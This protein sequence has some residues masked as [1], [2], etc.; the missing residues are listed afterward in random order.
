MQVKRRALKAK[1]DL[2]HACQDVFSQLVDCETVVAVYQI[3]Y[4]EQMQRQ[5]HRYASYTLLRG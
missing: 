3:Y 1:R 4:S 2:Q 5:A